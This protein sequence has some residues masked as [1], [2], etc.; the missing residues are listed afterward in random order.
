MWMEFEIWNLN[1]CVHCVMCAFAT[2]Y[3]LIAT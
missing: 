1:S 3:V 2:T